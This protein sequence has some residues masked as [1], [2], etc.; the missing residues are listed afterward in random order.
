MRLALFF[1]I[2]MILVTTYCSAQQLTGTQLLD[3]AIAYHDPQGKWPTFKG[4]LKISLKSANQS[5]RETYISIDLYSEFFQMRTEKDGTSI[6]QTIRKD[7]IQH[8]LNGSSDISEENLIKHR[9][10][11][12]RLRLL[13]N[14]YTY[15]YG[16][17]M[18][19][20]D[21]G[22]II[23]P[24][25]QDLEFK[26]KNYKVLTVTYD[27]NVGI[28]TWFFYFDPSTYAMEVYQ[29]FKQDPKNDGEYILLS[30]E[31]TIYG[32]KMPKN[33]AWY[34][35]KDDKHLGTDILTR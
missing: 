31:E 14:Y 20:K 26:G 15:L 34:H 7:T 33:R 9:I 18:K 12:N 4:D 21:F 22:T 30:G 17:P 2:S 29:F 28:D 8:L 24:V 35:N 10:T 13:K 11:D 5:T 19:L 32:I 27:K 23:D 3:K 25:V 1:S 16:L 6:L